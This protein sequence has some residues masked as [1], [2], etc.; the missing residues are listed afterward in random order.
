M[1]TFLPLFSANSLV[2]AVSLPPTLSGSAAQ[3]SLKILP[4]T[5]CHDWIG[6]PDK[7]VNHRPVHS[8]I[9]EKESPMKQKLREL[10]QETE[11]WNQKFWANQNLTFHKKKRTC[12]LKTKSLRPGNWSRIG[13]NSDIEWGR[14]GWLLQEFLS[15]NFQEHMYY[16]RDWYSPILPSPSSWGK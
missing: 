3:S 4:R 7:N 9:P 13:S 1:R 6:I 8:D 12:S 14:N 15:K 5:F 16:N 2:P 11:G 10:R